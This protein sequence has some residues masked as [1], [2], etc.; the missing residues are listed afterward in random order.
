MSQAARE[1]GLPMVVNSS[2]ATDHI[3][4]YLRHGADFVIT[5]A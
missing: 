3:V 2:D 5:P 1:A 4:D